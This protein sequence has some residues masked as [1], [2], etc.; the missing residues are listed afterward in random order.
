MNP[1]TAIEMDYK[2]ASQWENLCCPIN[3]FI[4]SV[5]LPQLTLNLSRALFFY[6]DFSIPPC[7]GL[8]NALR[9]FCPN[10]S[11]AQEVFWSYPCSPSPSQ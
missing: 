10:I 8:K 5:V 9:I 4:A 11:L 3:C 7:P 1:M 2:P 6:H